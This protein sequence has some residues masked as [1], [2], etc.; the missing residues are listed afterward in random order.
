MAIWFQ[1][2]DPVVKRSI[3]GAIA[4]NPTLGD[5]KLLC[6]AAFPFFLA[7]NVR[8]SRQLLADNDP[9]RTSTSHIVPKKRRGP[10][11]YREHGKLILRELERLWVEQDP[12]YLQLVATFR[13]LLA[14]EAAQGEE[15]T[16][17]K[18]AELIGPVPVYRNAA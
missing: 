10:A 13:E 15:P 2:G 18:P 11:P 8:P 16:E 1:V 6:D 4:S 14:K 7:T 3:I 5:K 12:K 17:R 9:T